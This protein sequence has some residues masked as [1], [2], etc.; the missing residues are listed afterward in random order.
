MKARLN[1]L[2]ANFQQFAREHDYQNQPILTIYLDIDP[3]KEENRR[4]TPA[5]SIELANQF[6]SLYA[7]LDPEVMKRYNIQQKK[8]QFEQQLAL[9]IDT[10][11]ENRTGRS[12]MILS[13]LDDITALDLQVPVET[14]VYFGMPRIEHLLYAMDKYKKY[15]LLALSESEIRAIELYLGRVTQERLIETNQEVSNRFGVG[16]T[17][18]VDRR[19]LEFEESYARDISGKINQ[20]FMDDPDF[21]R[22]ILGGNQKIAH[23][24]KKR[25]HPSVKDVLV[26]IE[27]VDLKASDTD[28]IEQVAATAE[29]F[30]EEH[31]LMVIE[32]LVALHNR[33][34]AAVIELNDV[35]E[36]LTTQR[37]KTL[38]V[39]YPFE[40]SAKSELIYE[41]ALQGV[42][43][44]VVFGAAK[45]RL[46]EL[47]GIGAFLYYG[48]R[49]G[50]PSGE[51]PRAG[52]A[53]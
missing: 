13:D 25:L 28:I 44:N 35:K 21:E 37:I 43:I 15:L 19:E 40:E 14:A 33:R 23:A 36:A 30:E 39:S 20:Y 5:W 6:K 16:Q 45:E 49:G 47:G 10:Y 31:D 32:D 24:V 1:E 2:L 4:E 12:V 22:L 42:G 8:T 50:H 7:S 11:L 18:A 53:A 17:R 41:A 51:Q 48:N 9:F 29:T 46:D 3:T 26:S 34:G 52:G 38:V 27:K